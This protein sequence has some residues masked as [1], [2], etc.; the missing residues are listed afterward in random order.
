MKKKMGDID[1]P[2][3]TKFVYLLSTEKGLTIFR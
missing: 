3:S 1:F 2:I